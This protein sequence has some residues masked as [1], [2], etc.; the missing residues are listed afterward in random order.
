M[1]V[2]LKPTIRCHVCG[3][4]ATGMM[5]W[6]RAR[7]RPVCRPCGDMEE[8]F[9]NP[10]EIEEWNRKIDERYGK[11]ATFADVFCGKPRTH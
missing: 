11:D 10:S 7:F 4:K 5:T 9:I 3:A 8:E 1:D 6:G 2:Y